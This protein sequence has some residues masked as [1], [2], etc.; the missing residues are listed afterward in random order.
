MENEGV[1]G[2]SRLEK[3]RYVVRCM[4]RTTN[5]IRLKER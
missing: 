4:Y 5:K 1:D 3:G 2:A